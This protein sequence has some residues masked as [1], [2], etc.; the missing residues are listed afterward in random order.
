MFHTFHIFLK[1]QKPRKYHHF[2]RSTRQK[3]Y[4]L[5][6]FF[7]LFS[8]MRVSVF[9]KIGIY[10]MFCV[11]VWFPIDAIYCSDVPALGWPAISG[12]GFSSA[13][14]HRCWVS[15]APSSLSSHMSSLE[16]DMCQRQAQIIEERVLKEANDIK[17]QKCC[18]LQHF[19]F[20]KA[21]NLPKNA[22]KYHF[23]F[24]F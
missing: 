13:L 11:F 16:K 14:T 20:R 24:R 1:L 21:K 3:C 23:F 9:K 10:G 19:E 6:W 22:L 2:L 4:N 15:A 8:K 18:N 12:L 5:Q 17:T 7:A